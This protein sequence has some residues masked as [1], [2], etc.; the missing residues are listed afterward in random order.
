MN[1]GVRAGFRI[2]DQNGY[3]VRGLYSC[4]NAG[5]I[6]CDSVGTLI[7][8][9]YFVTFADQPDPVAVNLPGESEFE[10]TRECTEKSAA[11]LMDIL[12]RVFVKTREIKA[13]LGKWRYAT[14]PRR[15]TVYKTRTLEGAA[16]EHFYA[17]TFSPIKAR[18]C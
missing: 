5:E 13:V 3:A 15:K 9:A 14:V 18:I 11:V 2:A 12:R 1:R 8:I 17:I 4:Q 10:A 16:D 7:G 6:T